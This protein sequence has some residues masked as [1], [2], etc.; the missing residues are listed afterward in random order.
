MLPT[1][2]VSVALMLAQ[3]PAAPPTFDASRWNILDPAAKAMPYLGRASLFL[4]NGL[5]LLRDSSFADGTIEFDVAMHGHPSFAGVAFRAASGE[6]YEL[7]Y[8][9]PHRSRQ[10]DA[11]QYTPIFAG[12][13]AWQLYSGDGYTAA[14]ELP[15]NRWLHVRVV[16]SGRKASLFVDGAT[17]PQLVVK[18]LKRPWAAGAVGLWGRLG[19]AHFS[20]VV[21]TSVSATAPAAP[22]EAPPADGAIVD[23]ELSPAWDTTNVKPDVLPAG[24]IVWSAARAEASGLLD[25]ARFRKSVR[26]AASAAQGSRDVVFARHAITEPA[27]RRARLV[28]AYSDAIHIFL[29]GKLLFAGE[30]AFRS[31]DPSFLGIASLGPDAIYLDLTTGRNELVFAITE[32]FGGWGLSARLER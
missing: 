5:A 3:A 4:D 13:E 26:T 29:N 6:D 21:V 30:S 2:L 15:A 31:R 22:A 32:T 18:D 20:N 14:A 10:P 11:L 25:I 19:G 28:F 9:R 27:A 8:L 17:E 23:W 16:V 1:L 24:S 7:I 12:S